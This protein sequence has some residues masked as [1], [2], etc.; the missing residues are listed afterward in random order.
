[1]GVFN[2]ALQARYIRHVHI[3]NTAAPFTPYVIMIVA[4]MVEPVNPAGDFP[5]SYFAHCAQPL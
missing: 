5:F 2:G 4:E 3:K 1:M